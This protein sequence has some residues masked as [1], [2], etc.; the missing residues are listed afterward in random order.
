MPCIA[1]IMAIRERRGRDTHPCT[2]ALTVIGFRRVGVD[3]AAHISEKL[4]KKMEKT[5]NFTNFQTPKL[6]NIGMVPV[7]E[8]TTREGIFQLV[9]S[10]QNFPEITAHLDG[11][12]RR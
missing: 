4:R 1:K 3:P 6:I 7:R 2:V 9:F 8:G 12:Q 11:A 5:P 10:E